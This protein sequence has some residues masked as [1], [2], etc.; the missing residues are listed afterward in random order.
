MDINSSDFTTVWSPCNGYVDIGRAKFLSVV[1]TTSKKTGEPSVGA[2]V[3]RVNT[4][5]FFHDP[6]DTPWSLPSGS[7]S[8]NANHSRCSQCTTAWPLGRFIGKIVQRTSLC[9]YVCSGL[10]ESGRA[11]SA[12]PEPADLVRRVCGLVR[13]PTSSSTQPIDDLAITDALIGLRRDPSVRIC[14]ADKGGALVVWCRAL[15]VSTAINHLSS[16]KESRNYRRLAGR[17]KC[18]ILIDAA[19]AHRF[20]LIEQLVSVA[21]KKISN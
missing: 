15:Y 12:D 13:S 1:P 17:M 6:R 20:Q 16:S 21:M 14:V 2:W 3:Q 18:S 19:T 7:S 4:A 5:A 11:W 10:V 8:Y 9:Q